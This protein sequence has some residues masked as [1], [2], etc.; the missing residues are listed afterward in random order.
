M[1]QRATGTRYEQHARHYLEQQA[2][3]TFV[4]AN[5][6]YRGGELD[7]IM[8]DE[9]TWVFVEV[10]YRKNAQFGSAAES[11]TSRKQQRLLQAA[12]LWLA[13]RQ[14]SF[15]TTSCRFDI[16]AITGEHYDWLP[17]AFGA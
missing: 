15:D 13:Q 12:A 3:L 6:H 16:L 7:L 8:R 4:A 17:N 10:R 1:N 14:Q 9:H 11:V 2:G 5:V